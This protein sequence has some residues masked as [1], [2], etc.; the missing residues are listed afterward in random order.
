MAI[1]TEFVAMTGSSQ[2]HPTTVECG[3]QPVLADDGRRLL[4][5]STYGSDQRQSHKKTSQTLQF[6]EDG[7][8]ELVRIIG[9]V[10]PGLSAAGFSQP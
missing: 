7:A 4:Q 2:P 9:E 10:F 1:V 5:L 6:D 8:R 3:Y